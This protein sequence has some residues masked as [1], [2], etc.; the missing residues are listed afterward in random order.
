MIPLPL[1]AFFNTLLR[2]VRSTLDGSIFY[3]VRYSAERYH[4]GKEFPVQVSAKR[5]INPEESFQTKKKNIDDALRRINNLEVVSG[6]IFSFW[7]VIGGANQQATGGIGR[8][9][10]GGLDDLAGLLYYVLLKAG[11][12]IRERHPHR[13]INHMR[14]SAPVQGGFDAWVVYGYKDLAFRN[15]KRVPVCIRYHWEDRNL[16]LDICSPEPIT[17]WELHAE[18]EHFEDKVRVKTFRSNQLGFKQ[19]ISTDIYRTMSV[20]RRITR[21]RTGMEV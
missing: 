2:F 10:G 14:D 4:K 1:R 6:E 9:Y 17:A 5:E 7:T 16:C 20:F 12:E 8:I 21:Q 13:L 3:M 11:F 18:H 19:R 15:N